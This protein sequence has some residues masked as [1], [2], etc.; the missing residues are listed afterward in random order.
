MSSPTKS[1]QRGGIRFR[2]LASASSQGSTFSTLW[3][4]SEDVEF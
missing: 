4:A 3:E 1:N 2:T